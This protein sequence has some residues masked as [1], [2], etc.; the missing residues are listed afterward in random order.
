MDDYDC[1]D[2]RQRKR[3]QGE[4]CAFERCQEFQF[5]TEVSAVLAFCEQLVLYQPAGIVRLPIRISN[6]FKR[7]LRH[8][9]M[10][11]PAFVDV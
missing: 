7:I 6:Q 10:H 4:K 9:Q 11:Y 5:L 8:K 3:L 2:P 1:H